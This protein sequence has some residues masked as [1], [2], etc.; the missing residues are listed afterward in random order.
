MAQSYF[1]Q[2]QDKALIPPKQTRLSATRS[3]K[4]L[5]CPVKITFLDFIIQ[6]S[7]RLNTVLSILVDTCPRKYTSQQNMILHCAL[8]MGLQLNSVLGICTHQKQDSD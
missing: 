1:V 6:I 2:W 7:F 8:H 3:C 5:N 4:V